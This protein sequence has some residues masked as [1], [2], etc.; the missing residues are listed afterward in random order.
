MLR[1]ATV[2]L[3]KEQIRLYLVLEKT[4]ETPVDSK[5]F[6][7]AN[8][9]GNQDWIFTERPDAETEAPRVWPPDGKEPT[10]WKRPWFWER[11]KA[12]GE[13]DNR[14][15]DGW[16]A[17]STQW[18]WVWANSGRWWRTGKPGVLQSMRS[19]S[20]TRLSEWTMTTR[21]HYNSQHGAILSKFLPWNL[22]VIS[23]IQ[24]WW[25]Q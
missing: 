9:K 1:T 16:M 21:P 15:W 10:H 22:Y 23:K 3:L 18:T 2:S 17:S 4:L 19:Q 5:E 25:K 7:P 14:E 12:R 20:Q 6:K 13:G 8:P 24:H 11:S